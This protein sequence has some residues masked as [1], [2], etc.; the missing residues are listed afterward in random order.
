MDLELRRQL[1]ENSKYGQAQKAISQM[2]EEASQPKRI[3][4]AD[5]RVI[6]RKKVEYVNFKETLGKIG[7]DDDWSLDTSS[8]QKAHAVYT[9]LLNKKYNVE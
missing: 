2:N 1:F 9:S 8:Y 4:L 5:G 7:E 6:Y 3:Q